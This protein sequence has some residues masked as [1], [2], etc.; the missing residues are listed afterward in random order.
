MFNLLGVFSV[1][2][3]NIVKCQKTMVAHV[4]AHNYFEFYFNGELIEKDS[5]AYLPQNAMSFAFEVPESGL[6]TFAFLA[7]DTSNSNGILRTHKK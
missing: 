5:V 2:L 4:Y 3:L 1:L 7:K 6:Y